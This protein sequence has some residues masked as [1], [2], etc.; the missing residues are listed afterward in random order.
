MSEYNEQRITYSIFVT[1]YSYDT[2]PQKVLNFILCKLLQKFGILV[3]EIYS[4]VLYSDGFTFSINDY[5][6]YESLLSMNGISYQSKQL[7]IT[8]NPIKIRKLGY[9]FTKIFEKYHRGT[10]IDLSNLSVKVNNEETNGKNINFNDSYFVEYFFI[11]LGLESKT[12][13]RLVLSLDLS[14]NDIESIETWDKYIL[15][16]P[17]LERIILRKNKFRLFYVP[18]LPSWKGVSL[19]LNNNCVKK[20]MYELPLQGKISHVS[21][22]DLSNPQLKSSSDP[23][24]S[25]P[26]SVSP[27]AADKLVIKKKK[28]DDSQYYYEDNI[29]LM[30]KIEKQ[31]IPRRNP[32]N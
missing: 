9:V 31:H 17:F 11:K 7:W 18:C 14:D 26:R 20:G 6:G 10:H 27:W 16:L 21:I 23:N 19:V 29:N 15:F 12:N 3:S 2:S 1:N 13:N 24:D 32:I 30:Q 22:D 4:K 25:K 8:R 5:Q 28:P